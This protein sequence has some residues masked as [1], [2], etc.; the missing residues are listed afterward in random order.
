MQKVQP[1]IDRKNYAISNKRMFD[2]YFKH[3]ITV[4]GL[5]VNNF[6]D[7]K[8]IHFSAPN[9]YMNIIFVENLF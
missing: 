2:F 1:C 8:T 9:K 6:I 5:I 7:N 4:S 3:A